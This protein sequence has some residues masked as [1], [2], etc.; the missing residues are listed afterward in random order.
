VDHLADKCHRESFVVLNNDA[1]LPLAANPAG[2]RARCNGSGDDAGLQ[3]LL[4]LASGAGTQCRLADGLRAELVLVQLGVQAAPGVQ[5]GV[6]AGRD[7]PALVKEQD[8]VGGSDG[9]QA[10]RDHQGG[11]AAQQYAQCGLDVVLG[12]AVQVRTAIATR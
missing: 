1:A 9:G 5:L 7:Q 2:A 8:L 10:V 11:A 3:N 6:G 4:W 12:D